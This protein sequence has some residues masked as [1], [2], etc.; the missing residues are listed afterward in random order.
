VLLHNT[1]L[2]GHTSAERA[3]RHRVDGLLFLGAFQETP[4]LP[5]SLP[6]LSLDAHCSGPNRG[7]VVF[8]NVDGIRLLVGHLYALGHRRIAYLGGPASIRPARDRVEAFLAE[9]GRLGIAPKPDHVR[10]GDWSAEYGYRETCAMLAAE[11]KPTAIVAAA[12]VAA[13]GAMQA[14]R[15]Y[16]FE[17][18]RD[19]AVTGFDDLPAA[20]LSYPALTTIR[21][22]RERLGAVA[23]TTLFEMLEAPGEDGP[24]VSLPV[25]L[26]VRASSGGRVG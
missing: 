19:I 2:H 10:E 5:A 24:Q 25:S 6:C 21:Q 18:G 3:A 13:I 1:P 16:G 20:S 8:D 11:D 14:I 26:V 9:T 22:D 7:A 23:V 15:D 4:G 17:P 12:D